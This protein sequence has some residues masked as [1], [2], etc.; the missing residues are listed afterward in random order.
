M[1][2]SYPAVR[3]AMAM[4]MVAYLDPTS[5]RAMPV[6]PYFIFNVLVAP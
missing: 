4:A 1:E 6:S 2:L 3:I 5:L